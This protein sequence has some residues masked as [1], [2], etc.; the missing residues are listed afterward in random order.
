MNSVIKR[1]ESQCRE[2]STYGANPILRQDI[3]ALIAECKKHNQT[4]SESETK[5]QREIQP[6][7]F[8]GGKANVI[9]FSLTIIQPLFGDP[10]PPK[11]KYYIK[12]EKCDTVYG[13]V[14]FEK[15]EQAI[16]AW[17]TRGQPQRIIKRRF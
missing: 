15:E 3:E 16:T 6:C 1:L 17:N 2:L 10:L 13:A 7:P 12:C 8:C 14:E 9:T 4:N 11:N 5:K